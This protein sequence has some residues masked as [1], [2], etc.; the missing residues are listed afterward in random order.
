MKKYYGNGETQ[1]R[2]RLAVCATNLN[3]ILLRG[4]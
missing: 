3:E 1:I 2:R 4:D